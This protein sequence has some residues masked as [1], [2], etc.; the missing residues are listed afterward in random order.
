M[1]LLFLPTSSRLSWFPLPLAYSMA[2]FL[3][4]IIVCTIRLLFI[5]LSLVSILITV[6][7]VHHFL[8]PGFLPLVPKMSASPAFP[9]F[10][11]SSCQCFIFPSLIVCLPS[12]LLPGSLASCSLLPVP[13]LPVSLVFQLFTRFLLPF[14]SSVSDVLLL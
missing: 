4:F 5:T 2:S 6:Q 9:V 13:R 3:L 11:L 12:S 8:V 7:V 1:S 14:P 10:F